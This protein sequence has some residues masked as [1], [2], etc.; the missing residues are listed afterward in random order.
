MLLQ[1]RQYAISGAALSAQ[2]KLLA[3]ICFAQTPTTTEVPAEVVE[4][5]FL[6]D[7]SSFTI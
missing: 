5:E 7:Y 6:Q 2:E 3:A 4:A 1:N